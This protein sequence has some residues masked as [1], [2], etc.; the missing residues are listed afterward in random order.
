MTCPDVDQV[1]N[2]SILGVF[3]GR[4]G[5]TDRPVREKP[6]ELKDS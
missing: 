6:L 5:L 4:W 3:L 2:G 1:A